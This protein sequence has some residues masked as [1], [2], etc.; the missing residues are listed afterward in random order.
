MK[1]QFTSNRISQFWLKPPHKFIRFIASLVFHPMQ[2]AALL[3]E[4]PRSAPLKNQITEHCRF[5]SIH[6]IVTY[7]P[8]LKKVGHLIIFE[9]FR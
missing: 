5:I 2:V 8:L 4:N 9:K 1:P 7:I 6:F 3:R